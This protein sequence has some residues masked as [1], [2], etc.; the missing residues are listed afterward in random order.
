MIMLDALVPR[1]VVSSR[2]RSG[3]LAYKQGQRKKDNPEPGNLS[4]QKRL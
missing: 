4:S 2:H 1:V 3:G